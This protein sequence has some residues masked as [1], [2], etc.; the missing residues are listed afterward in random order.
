M[1]TTIDTLN[2]DARKGSM[3]RMK[4]SN[5]LSPINNI[6]STKNKKVMKC[7]ENKE[8]NGG[9]GCKDNWNFK[10]SLADN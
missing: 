6:K 5:E 3:M 8:N 1:K 4:R 7:K 2:I 9:G 10:T